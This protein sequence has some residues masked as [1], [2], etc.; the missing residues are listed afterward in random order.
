MRSSERT[1]SRSLCS[2]RALSDASRCA[3]HTCPGRCCNQA[4]DLPY[5]ARL[6]WAMGDTWHRRPWAPSHP[7]RYCR[8]PC[9]ATGEGSVARGS[10]A[11]GSLA[12]QNDP[13]RPPSVRESSPRRDRSGVPWCAPTAPLRGAQS[14][15]GLVR[16]RRASL[17]PPSAHPSTR[18]AWSPVARASRGLGPTRTLIRCATHSGR[19]AEPRQAVSTH[20]AARQSSCRPPQGWYL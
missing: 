15:R 3:R 8:P 4:V 5:L 12:V 9:H 20:H 10:I 2:V 19:K 1:H 7:V 16:A 18:S 14:G 13:L 17:Q 11:W 6:M